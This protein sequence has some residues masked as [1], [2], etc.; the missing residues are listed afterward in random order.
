MRSLTGPNITPDKRL[1]AAVVAKFQDTCNSHPNG[2]AG[3]GFSVLVEFFRYVGAL[4][5]QYDKEFVKKVFERA[6][7]HGHHVLGDIAEGVATLREVWGP[8]EIG[9]VCAR[10]Q[11]A[12]GRLEDNGDIV[13]LGRLLS[14]FHTIG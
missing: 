12:Y 7:L 5:V 13:Q 8:R 11:T 4:E 6:M 1:A 3:V 9:R 10:L 2:I 14:S